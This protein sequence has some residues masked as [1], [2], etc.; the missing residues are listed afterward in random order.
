MTSSSFPVHALEDG[1]NI[2]QLQ[3][4]LGHA[5]VETTLRYQRCILP[6][7]ALSPLD[8]MEPATQAPNPG[9]VGCPEPHP[10]TPS[11]DTHL[12]PPASRTNRL[13]DWLAKWRDST[14]A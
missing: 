9:P 14:A 3:T 13:R 6:A 12:P 5:S 8:R 10:P 4:L 7:E 11:Q 1:M 2:R